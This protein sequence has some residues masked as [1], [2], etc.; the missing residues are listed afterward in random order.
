MSQAAVPSHALRDAVHHGRRIMVALE[1]RAQHGPAG[2][3]RSRRHS[4]CKKVGARSAI[5]GHSQLSFRVNPTGRPVLIVT[6][7]GRAITMFT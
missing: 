1:I 7:G 6:E 4:R 2:L 3:W 5:V